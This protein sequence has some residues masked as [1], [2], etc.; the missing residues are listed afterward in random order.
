MTLVNL[1]IMTWLSSEV[2]VAINV[3]SIYVVRLH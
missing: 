3:V 1:E 2:K